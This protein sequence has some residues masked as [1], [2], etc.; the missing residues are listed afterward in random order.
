[1][2]CLPCAVS[3]SRHMRQDQH[4]HR[5]VPRGLEYPVFNCASTQPGDHRLHSEMKWPAIHK[6]AAR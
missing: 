4:R 2:H 6:K 1:M 5:P 3:L